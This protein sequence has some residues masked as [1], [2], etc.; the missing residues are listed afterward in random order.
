MKGITPCSRLKVNRRF[1]RTCSLHL[2]C[3][4]VSQARNHHVRV[5]SNRRDAFH[6][7]PVSH[8][9]PRFPEADYFVCHLL[10]MVS[11]LAHSSTLKIQAYVLPK[12]QLTFNGLY[13]VINQKDRNLHKLASWNVRFAGLFSTLKME[14]TCS[15]ETSVGF[16]RTTRRYN[17]ED[18]TLHKFTCWKGGFAVVRAVAVKIAAFCNLMSCG[19]PASCWLHSWLT[20]RP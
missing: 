14:A 3:R 15:F 13:G 17:P 20:H 19:L 9:N 6:F 7:P 11:F 18:R 1:E 5:K 12:R 10:L 8:I 4:I 16:Q 2:Y